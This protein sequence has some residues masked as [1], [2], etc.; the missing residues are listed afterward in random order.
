MQTFLHYR[1]R[2]PSTLHRLHL[3]RIIPLLLLALCV[4]E[5]KAQTYQTFDANK[6]YTKVLIDARIHDFKGNTKPMGF[7]TYNSETDVITQPQWQTENGSNRDLAID[8]VA[9]LVAKA[10]IE[11]AVY[12]QDFT[13]SKPWFKLVENYA[14]NEKVIVPT[15][16]AS[17]DDLNAAKMYFALADLTNKGA[18]Y[19]N[20]TTYNRAISEL[21][22][23]IDGL[24]AVNTDYS[25]HSGS[26]VNYYSS[27][28]G[29]QTCY[30]VDA[31]NNKLLPAT[32]GMNAIGGWY[33]K[34]TY[35]N[36]M[37]CDSEYMGPAL[38]AQ[39]V[40]Y[41]TEN[42]SAG[43]G[44]VTGTT[45]GDWK[46][47]AKQFDITW[48]YLWNSTD[49]L[50]YH[51]F[52]AT[53]TAIAAHTHTWATGGNGTNTAYWGR[54]IGW[55]F[56]ALV[57]VLENMPNDISDNTYI[58]TQTNLSTR[59]ANI[60]T[61]LKSYLTDLAAGIWKQ[62]KSD[63]KLWTNVINEAVGAEHNTYQT[64]SDALRS[65][66]QNYLEAS[67][68]AIY[69][70]AY[71]KAMRLELLPETYKSDIETA[72]KNYISN[73][74]T[75]DNKIINTCAS[76]GL[77]GGS[78]NISSEETYYKSGGKRYRNGTAA[79]YTRGYDV[80][81]VTS[82]QE[83]K[84]LGAFIL[85]STEYE[86]YMKAD[87][88]PSFTATNAEKPTAQTVTK[89]Q[90]VTLHAA[91]M[92]KPLATYQWYSYPASS[93]RSTTTQ[94]TAIEGAKSADLTVSPEVN[95]YYYCVA[96]NSVGSVQTDPVLV[97]VNEADGSENDGSGT[98]IYQYTVK[99]N[100]NTKGIAYPATGGTATLGAAKVE[101]GKGFKSDKGMGST[102]YIKVELTGNTLQ[103][104]DVITIKAYSAVNGGGIYIAT[105]TAANSDHV[106][107]GNLSAK[108][109]VEEL[110]Y[111]V[112]GTDVLKGLSTIYLFR[113][114]ATDNTGTSTYIQEITITRGGSSTGTSGYTITYSTSVGTA[115]ESKSD[116]T[117]LTADELPTLS[118]DGYTFV[119]W[120]TDSELTTPAVAG[121][122][123][124]GNTTLYAKWTINK[125]TVTATAENG[126]IAIKDGNDNPVQTNTEVE[127][128]TSLTF[129]ATPNDGYEF[130]SWS[131]T[132]TAGT[133]NGATYTIASLTGPTTVTANF[134]AKST[135]G[136]ETGNVVT[137]TGTFP[138]SDMKTF[139]GNPTTGEVSSISK[140]ANG[141]TVETGGVLTL[142]SESP[143]VQAQ[144]N[145]QG[146]KVRLGGSFTITAA[147]G[148]TIKSIELVT[149]QS[150]RNLTSS[151][152]ATPERNGTNY[153]YNFTKGEQSVTF[154]NN[155]SGN[156]YVGVINVTYEFSAAEGKTPLTISFSESQKEGYVGET[157]TLPTP[158]VTAN[159]TA[160]SSGVYNVT[161]KSN[162]ETIATVSNEG[163]VTLK[164]AG[165][166]AI[167]AIVEPTTGNTGQ[168]E[169]GSAVITVVS[170]A[171]T[172]LTVSVADVMMNSNDGTQTN[173]D[174]KVYLNNQLVASSNYTVSYEVTRGDNVTAN[175]STLTV[176]K[177]EDGSYTAG[178]S[179]ITVTV[180]PTETFKSANHCAEGTATFSYVV[181][182]AGTKLKP[183]IDFPDAI[184]LGTKVT[185]T[186]ISYVKYNGV[187]VTELFTKNYVI[188]DKGT[189]TDASFS[190]ATTG[191]FKTGTTAATVKIKITV[192]PVPNYA[193]QYESAEKE[194][195][196]T[197][198]E[199]TELTISQPDDKT[200]KVGYVLDMPSFEIKDKSGNA[201]SSDEFEFVI[202]SSSTSVVTVSSDKSK[203]YAVG[204]GTATI[205]VLAKDNT[206][207]SKYMDA[208][209]SFKVTVTDPSLHIVEK[210][211]T[212][213]NGQCITDVPNV[214]MTYGG[215]VFNSIKTYL[216]KNYGS[217]KWNAAATDAAGAPVG[218]PYAVMGNGHEDSRDELGASAAPEGK[219][220]DY[221][222]KG[223]KLTDKMFSVPAEGAYF[224]FTPKVNGTVVAHVLQNGVFDPGYYNGK[225]AP[226]YKP[227]RRVFVVDEGGNRMPDNDIIAHLDV[228]TGVPKASESDN[229]TINGISYNFSKN[230]RILN[231]GLY[232]TDYKD[233]NE[234]TIYL[235]TD[236]DFNGSTTNTID[237]G[238]EGFT[239]TID[240]NGIIT[241]QNKIY[242]RKVNKDKDNVKGGY[243]VLS[244]A[245]VTYTFKVKAGKSYY[246]YCFGSKLSLYGYEFK[247][248][249]T[250]TED[251]VTL[252]ETTAPTLSATEKGH[253]AKVSLDRTFKAGIWNAC[254][255]PFSLNQYQV[256][257][258]FGKTYDKGHTDGTQILYFDRVE[259]SK[260]YFVR[261]AYN[262]IVAG[263]PFLIKPTKDNATINT[264]IIDAFPYVTIEATA[265]P[266]AFGKGNDYKWES[267]YAPFG[268]EPGDYFL[269]DTQVN[270]KP[271]DGN[272]VRYP[273]ALTTNLS[274][275]GFRGYL[276]AQTDGV[277]KSTKSMSIVIGS[278]DD[279][280]TT[281]IEDVVLDEDGTL[282]PALKGKVYNIQGQLMTTDASRLNTLPKGIYIINGSKITVE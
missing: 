265:Q 127:H 110:K 241:F 34:A 48:N 63:T 65:N 60:K 4:T 170:K 145:D 213:S 271:A 104:G 198:K 181:N 261:H 19:E 94:G 182:K 92:A 171:Y 230:D 41:A 130:T 159:G 161:Y 229:G 276:K 89:G 236:Y 151:P 8:Y 17:L 16:G 220:I 30:L 149:D 274:M 222:S 147:S 221:E 169:G 176:V 162:N 247:A 264:A 62:M 233:A 131:V 207:Q 14:T 53:P 68:S 191:E 190:N 216:E 79:Y 206:G 3:R 93:T 32:S 154:I 270:G 185:Q 64:T 189:S 158:T 173:P 183:V 249:E 97:T 168:Y 142:S 9:G 31:N 1:W 150:S 280:E 282:R 107:A 35:P 36:Q 256:D 121:A 175:G 50:L 66:T 54:A 260:M 100:E 101:E 223:F 108:N 124:S 193:D 12:Y 245:P 55:Y 42:T 243:V 255:L 187:D 123:I 125:Y 232:K 257:A 109:T 80:T 208:T 46:L 138:R 43:I 26:T 59:N 2:V 244:K 160:A 137:K 156:I 186:L 266:A 203:L 248:D 194:V 120:Y 38:L 278:V 275:N 23:A 205:I 272:M 11:A 103:A 148:Y 237:G 141:G 74:I 84:P 238:I 10:C 196:V 215:W 91:A 231:V 86:R 70:A 21:K 157:I 179:V 57:D 226:S 273:A 61:R 40:A 18:K 44:T 210:G 69:I 240:K 211:A 268:V 45:E 75:T 96:T 235:S 27:S 85:A 67:A 116:I 139:D 250:V 102:S 128:G 146:A 246:L 197:I 99:S 163:Q 143:N 24:K 106:D 13:W 71:I 253:M 49:K 7:G 122:T 105:A 192:T 172:P 114:G 6:C 134:T 118:A 58:S 135:G 136:G 126:S 227:N 242:K 164:A 281:L 95:T 77:G 178:T 279:D 202:N 201:V 22:H 87:Y 218:F 78:V 152:D 199:L 153:T 277:R 98:V 37:W 76:A 225:H 140:D 204:A 51:G 72:Y 90:S 166:V 133:E 82:Y 56:L 119:G 52:S 239:P 113:N 252:S 28:E 212:A 39:L 251:V 217:K 5:A 167:T 219:T 111:T 81:K 234:K 73:F 132:G 112:T 180:T 228:T 195:T 209:T 20:S 177:K 88:A 262:H 214:Y 47:I 115:P 15:T 117:T 83:G 263:K 200:V 33:H 269:R 29:K 258:I 188:T 224:V 267:S 129:T 259:G 144:Q 254:V 155:S 165:T 25:I 184:T 174:V